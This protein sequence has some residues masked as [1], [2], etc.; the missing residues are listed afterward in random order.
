MFDEVQSK[1]IEQILDF[2]SYSCKK[3]FFTLPTSRFQFCYRSETN[4]K[5]SLGIGPRPAQ[6]QESKNDED[7]KTKF[8][9]LAYI[10]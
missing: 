3:T 6:R 2:G 1:C 7:D 10:I 4:G 9:D 5:I 8:K